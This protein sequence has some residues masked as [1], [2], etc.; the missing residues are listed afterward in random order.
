MEN[1]AK[2]LKLKSLKV[3]YKVL[4]VTYDVFWAIGAKTWDVCRAIRRVTD[5]VV[6]EI[7]EISKNIS[8]D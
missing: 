7:V 4:D 5:K 8:E 2:S 1:K 6:K 3:P